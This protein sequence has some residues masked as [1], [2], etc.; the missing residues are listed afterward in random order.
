MSPFSWQCQNL[1]LLSLTFILDW[2]VVSVFSYVPF[3]SKSLGPFERCGCVRVLLECWDNFFYFTKIRAHLEFR[4]LKETKVNRV[5]LEWRVCQVPRATKA[6]LDP[7]GPEDRR[8]TEVEWVFLGSQ[9]STEFTATKDP[10]DP[11]ENQV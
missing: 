6:I 9:A 10:S 5:S 4:G 1:C 7:K 8:V 3:C 11:R 2:R